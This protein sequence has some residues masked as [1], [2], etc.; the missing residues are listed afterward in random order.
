[1]GNNPRQRLQTQRGGPF[2]RGLLP[3]VRAATAGSTSRARKA[4]GGARGRAQGPE[5]ISPASTTQQ[6]RQYGRGHRSSSHGEKACHKSRPPGLTA[7]RTAAMHHLSPSRFGSHRPSVSEVALSRL[8]CTRSAARSS[9]ANIGYLPSRQE[10]SGSELRHRSGCL[11]PRAVV[12][13]ELRSRW[14]TEPA[15]PPSCPVGENAE[16]RSVLLCSVLELGSPGIERAGNCPGNRSVL[17]A[18]ELFGGA[19]AN[20]RLPHYRKGLSVWPQMLNE[21]KRAGLSRRMTR[22]VVKPF[23]YEV[24]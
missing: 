9:P 22:G 1:M 19:V 7:S 4:S 6:L 24:A 14:R 15:G 18:T 11:A 2:G 23:T 3:R 16:A 12:S 17:G 13:P 10:S 21:T 20:P 8:A 5:A